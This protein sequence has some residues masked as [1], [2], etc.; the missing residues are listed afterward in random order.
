MVVN[1]LRLDVKNK[2]IFTCMN[3]KMA[4]L[5]F[6]GLLLV[7]LYFFN[8]SDVTIT[9]QTNFTVT[10]IGNSGLLLN[11]VI[12]FKNP[13]L[14]SSTINTI[15]EQFFIEGRE[16]A[17]MNMDL[18]QGIPGMKESSFPVNVRFSKTDLQR[19]FGTDTLNATQ[20]AQLQVLGEISFKNMMNSGKITVNQKDSISLPT[21]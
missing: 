6:T 12:T 8:R 13:N 11:S 19:I 16:V 7:A 3:L 2:N 18:Q 15:S 17:R 5:V 1:N 9:G 14:L 10:P 4:G 21:Y 20:K